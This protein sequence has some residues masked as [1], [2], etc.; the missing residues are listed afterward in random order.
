MSVGQGLAPATIYKSN[1]STH[2]DVL[3]YTIRQIAVYRSDV[4][5]TELASPFGRGA[6]K[7][8]RGYKNTL[9]VTPTACQLSQRESQGRRKHQCAKLQFLQQLKV[10]ATR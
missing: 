8:R 7:G 5:R 9:S 3:R 2:F 4:H 6:P 10:T 1:R